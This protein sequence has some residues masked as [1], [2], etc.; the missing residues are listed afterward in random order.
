MGLR[1]TNVLFST[2]EVS[3]RHLRERSQGGISEGERS[4]EKGM[5][6]WWAGEA[7]RAAVRGQE[8]VGKK[9]Q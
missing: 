5:R 7:S 6:K 9:A 8:G 1:G 4:G 3:G 2:C